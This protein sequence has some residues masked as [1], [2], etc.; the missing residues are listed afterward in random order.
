[1]LASCAAQSSPRAEK[2]GG[3]GAELRMRQSDAQRLAQGAK[4]PD[5]Q[6]DI[7]F[8]FQTLRTW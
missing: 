3:R 5:P 1:M 6:V 7:K 2:H 4:D 8:S